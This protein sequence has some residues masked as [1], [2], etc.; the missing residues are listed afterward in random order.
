MSS[1][2]RPEL[3]ERWIDRDGL[4][5]VFLKPLHG[6]ECVAVWICGGTEDNDGFHE[7]SRA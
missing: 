3:L 6:L 4:V 7:H 2:V 1:G 5:A